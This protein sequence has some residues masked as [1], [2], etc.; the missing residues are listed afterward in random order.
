MEAVLATSRS[1]RIVGSITTRVEW[2]VG[3]SLG[4]TELL[5]R[6]GTDWRVQVRAASVSVI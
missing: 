6:C 2:E 4:I 3:G 1:H 5:V